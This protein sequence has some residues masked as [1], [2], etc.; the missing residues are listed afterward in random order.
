MK[1][2]NFILFFLT[3]TILT[4][5]GQI[6][7]DDLV[8]NIKGLSESYTKRFKNSE[9]LDILASTLNQLQIPQNIAPLTINVTYSNGSGEILAEISFNP[10]SLYAENSDDDILTKQWTIFSNNGISV[11]T[12]Y[13]IL[14]AIGQYKQAVAKN[15]NGYSMDKNI[16]NFKNSVK[17]KKKNAD[18]VYFQGF[19]S[20]DNNGF[21]PFYF[22]TNALLFTNGKL[23]EITAINGRMLNNNHFF[24]VGKFEGLDGHKTNDY[25][26]VKFFEVS[27]L[28]DNNSSS[29][30]NQK[31]NQNNKF[32]FII[33]E[34]TYDELTAGNSQYV[35]INDTI[36]LNKL[37]TAQQKK[38]LI[39]L[40][41]NS[42]LLSDYS[43]AKIGE[44][45][46][47]NF[48]VT[49]FSSRYDGD[50]IFIRII[51][52]VTKQ[53]SD[54]IIDS[55]E[56]SSY[57]DS[58]FESKVVILTMDKTGK[59]KLTTHLDKKSPI[60]KYLMIDNNGKII[61]TK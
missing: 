57:T 61:A 17:L 37:L 29:T 26:F 12:F 4:A 60:T 6:S 39:S 52:N 11:Y 43:F 19:N 42:D 7:N 14:T 24:C 5:K 34:T 25:Q 47:N 54:K 10:N 56:V 45:K 58:D 44:R 20:F 18:W 32:P 50:G 22:Y 35:S 15:E 59:M 23:T 13:K 27:N 40:N 21:F 1:H 53:G 8:V 16:L 9:N 28:N 49:F 31:T 46:I 33:D 2:L 48:K 38:K 41:N 3:F 55:K 30:S 51:A 36:E